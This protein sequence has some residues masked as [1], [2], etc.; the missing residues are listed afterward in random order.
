MPFSFTF[1][2]TFFNLA[3]FLRKIDRFVRLKESG[4]G[5]SGRLLTIDGIALSVSPDGF[6][7]IKASVAA[8][9][10]L[11]P[12]EQGVFGGASPQAPAGQT[13][14]PPPSSQTAAPPSG[15]KA[16]PAAGGKA[17]TPSGGKATPGCGWQGGHALG[18]Q[19]DPARGR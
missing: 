16:T 13:A 1:T 4:V 2:G 8:T 9:A 17:A 7:S 3:D 18:R 5:V 12:E 14:P 11:L 10:Y 6:P 19:G 15:G